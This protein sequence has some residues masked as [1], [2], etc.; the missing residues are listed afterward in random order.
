MIERLTGQFFGPRKLTVTRDG[1]D[2]R[3]IYEENTNK[4]IE[5]IDLSWV[6][7]DGDKTAVETSFYAVKER[8]V[9]CRRGTFGKPS[10]RAHFEIRERTFPD[11]VLN[12]ELS[13][14]FGWIDQKPKVETAVSTTFAAAAAT[15]SSS[16]QSQSR[17]GGSLLKFDP[18][19]FG[20]P[21][22]PYR[23]PVGHP[24]ALGSALRNGKYYY[25]GKPDLL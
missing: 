20:H 21:R 3:L 16:H 15:R 5:F 1:R 12:V 9:K 7:A 18:Q 24:Q 10:E 25:A 22:A 6:N 4:I 19:G 11:S 23:F 2:G 17:S 13:A 8:Y 14:V